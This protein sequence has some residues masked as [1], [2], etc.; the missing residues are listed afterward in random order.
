MS[1]NNLFHLFSVELLQFLL[2]RMCCNEAMIIS[3][4][5]VDLISL[6]NVFIGYILCITNIILH[7]GFVYV[8]HLAISFNLFQDIADIS[9]D[10]ICKKRQCIPKAPELQ[11][12]AKSTHASKF[13]YSVQTLATRISILFYN[14]ILSE[15][16]IYWIIQIFS[17]L[18]ILTLC[19]QT[20]RMACG[21]LTCG[22]QFVEIH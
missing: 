9:K 8:S 7:R 19:R 2:I 16:P 22:L 4:K 12:L 6:L 10:T 3:C 13:S 15:M 1:C 18:F 21:V 17:F 20:E 14:Q 11:Y 5:C